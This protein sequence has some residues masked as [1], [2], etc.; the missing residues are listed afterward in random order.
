[1]SWLARGVE[2]VKSVMSL[3]M[4]WTTLDASATLI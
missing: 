1:M 3:L 2:N 4:V